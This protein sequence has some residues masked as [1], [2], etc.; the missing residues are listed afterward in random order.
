M[1]ET[2]IKSPVDRS[3]LTYEEHMTLQNHET[4]K[5]IVDKTEEVTAG[6]T[7]KKKAQTIMRARAAADDL[8]KRM[9]AEIMGTVQ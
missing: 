2:L 9:S 7:D 4:M 6:M 5:R 8:Q 3:M 1:S